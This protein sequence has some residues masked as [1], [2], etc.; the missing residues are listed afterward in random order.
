MPSP[1]GEIR[2]RVVREYLEKF[3]NTANHTLAKKIKKDTQTLFDDTEQI[4]SIIRVYRGSSGEKQRQEIQNRRF[5]RD[6]TVQSKNNKYGIPES[7][8]MEYP[9]FKIP[10]VHNRI[11]IV[12]D[13]H[14][15]YHDSDTMTATIDWAKEHDINAVLLNGDWIDFY[16]LSDFVRDPRKKNF[17]EEREVFWRVMDIWQNQLPNAVFYYK[18]ANHEIRFERRLMV[19]APE[20]Y[21]TEEFRLDIL[22]KLGERGIIAIGDKIK[23]R[24]GKLTCIH[25]DEYRGGASNLISPARWLFNKARGNCCCGHF[26][27]TSAYSAISVNEELMGCFSMGTMCDLHPDYLPNNDWNAGFARVIVNPDETFK[28]T[29][30]M[31]Y[32]G[33]VQ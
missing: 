29:N 13:A 24:I 25:G 3:P 4:R 30:L 2:G 15:P 14:I 1:L 16:Q 12:Q 11:L 19:K 32:D 10:S 26:H 18:F 31:I 7:D 22:F 8:A 28:F 21:G 6:K 5:F 23:I 9:I 20:L 27:K 33:K 17:P